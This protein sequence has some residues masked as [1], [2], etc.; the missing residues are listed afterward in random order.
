[1]CTASNAASWD[2]KYVVF[3]SV[4]EGMDVIEKIEAVGSDSGQTSQ[5]VTIENSGQLGRQDS[6]DGKQEI[7]DSENQIRGEESF[8]V[9]DDCAEFSKPIESTSDYKPLTRLLREKKQ[10]YTSSNASPTSEYERWRERQRTPSE[11]IQAYSPQ[12]PSNTAAFPWYTPTTWPSK[13]TTPRERPFW[14]VT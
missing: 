12:T 8:A 7:A 11:D 3:G 14:R 10:P 2:G 5:V 6:E 9:Y 1:M 13:C 4:V